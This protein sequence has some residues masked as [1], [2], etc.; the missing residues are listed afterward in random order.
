MAVWAVIPAAGAGERF[1]GA[2][3]KQYYKL[4]GRPMIAHVLSLF[5]DA[6]SIDG[7]AVAFAPNDGEWRALMPEQCPKPLV[8]AAGGATRADSVLAALSAISERVAVDDWAVVHD[9]ARPCLDP[10]ELERLVSTFADD[11]VGGIL[12]VPV[13]DTLKQSDAAGRIARTVDRTGLWRALTP[14]MF[15]YGLLRDALAEALADGATVTDEAMA[16][17]R[18]GHSPR[19]VAG[20][21]D[22]VK[23]TRMQDVA[24]A[25]AILAARA[26]LPR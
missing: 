7:I 26:A 20:S 13:D 19:L 10:V 15:R 22:N 1:G 23:V 2:C 9:A 8:T 25:E 16:M 17:E 4:G 24:M 6:P 12:A 3:A 14:Q 21:A 18:A 5:L 11:P